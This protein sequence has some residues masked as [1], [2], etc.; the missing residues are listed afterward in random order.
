LHESLE[1]LAHIPLPVDPSGRRARLIQEAR[2]LRDSERFGA[3]LIHRELERRY[4]EGIVGQRAVSNWI[5]RSALQPT[6]EPVKPWR[7][8]EPYL[9]QQDRGYLLR[10][11]LIS[12][13]VRSHGLN[14]EEARIATQLEV[15]LGGLDEIAKFALIEEYARRREHTVSPETDDLDALVTTRPWRG[16]DSF[17]VA[18]RR[19]GHGSWPTISRM[20]LGSK[21]SA[22]DLVIALHVVI[23]LGLAAT[24]SG[25]CVTVI[26]HEIARYIVQQASADPDPIGAVKRITDELIVD[27]TTIAEQDIKSALEISNVESKTLNNWESLLM[28]VWEHMGSDSR[29]DEEVEVDAK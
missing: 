26:T 20:N 15:A 24:I 7:K 4:G 29:I 22:T 5:K 19:A 16:D 18:A 27:R 1:I 28:R 2:I 25:N 13:T 9:W 12:Q 11:D 8:W 6:P 17:Y 23:A 21:A 10:L 3:P 14:E